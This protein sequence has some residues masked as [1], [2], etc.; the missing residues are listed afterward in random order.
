LAAVASAGASTCHANCEMLVAPKS[1]RRQLLFC[2]G[3]A[4]GGGETEETA[5]ITTLPRKKSEKGPKG[6]RGPRLPRHR[7]SS[8][9]CPQSLGA[10]C[11]R[12]PWK[13]FSLP[14]VSFP[15]CIHLLCSFFSITSLFPSSPISHCIRCCS[16]SCISIH[17]INIYTPL[18]CCPQGYRGLYV[19]FSFPESSPHSANCSSSSCPEQH[20]PFEPPPHP[21]D[22][23]LHHHL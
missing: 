21:S 4:A 16:S 19:L 3:P 9:N 15:R 2:S 14:P 7:K 6:Q 13:F 22:R 11:R 20:P 5:Y 12:A 17:S 10:A 1:D 23:L 18:P 8:A